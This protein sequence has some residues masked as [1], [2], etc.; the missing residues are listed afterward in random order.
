MR[1]ELHDTFRRNIQPG[2][3]TEHSL[4]YASC[5]GGRNRGCFRRPFTI[6]PEGRSQIGEVALFMYREGLIGIA[7]PGVEYGEDGVGHGRTFADAGFVVIKIPADGGWG[8]DF[9]RG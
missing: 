2:E 5:A 7:Q 8:G 6:T 3:A 9:F 1:G 4:Q